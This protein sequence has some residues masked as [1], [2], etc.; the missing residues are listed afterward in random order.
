M[1]RTGGS[2][3]G[4]SLTNT[5]ENITRKSGTSCGFVMADLDSLDFLSQVTL[6]LYLEKYMRFFWQ[7][8]TAP[9]LMRSSILMRIS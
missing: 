6:T 5:L 8:I 4:T 2:S 7:S 9:S 3:S 1:L